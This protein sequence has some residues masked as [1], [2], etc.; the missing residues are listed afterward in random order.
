MHMFQHVLQF[1]SVAVGLFSCG[2]LAQPLSAQDVPQT[3]LIT[4]E[5]FPFTVYHSVG[6]VDRARDMARLC[7]R[8]MEHMDSLLGFRPDVE[9]K[10]LLP[11]DWSAHTDFP[12][13]GMAHYTSQG[14]LV[15]AAVNNAMWDS[16][17]P[18][19]AELPAEVAAEV[20]RV[21]GMADGSISMQPF[22][23]LLV[24]HELGHAYHIQKPAAIPRLW[25]GEQF[26]N[27]LLHTFIAEREPARLD[28]LTLMPQLVVE[29]GSEGF[30]F[31]TL[32]QLED[33]YDLVGQQH[34]RNYGW[35]Q[36]RWH[37]AAAD[38]HDEA[39]DL[40]LRRLWAFLL[41]DP[42]ELDDEELARRLEAEVHPAVARVMTAW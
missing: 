9:L 20:R 30:L 22:F 24:L 37:K 41:S 19:M 8:T 27:I 29:V 14:T 12:V 34:P 23:D 2:P 1:V 11:E 42:G 15:M 38:I 28:A 31:T 7:L 5:G 3:G 4:L 40:A 26:C 13:Y 36:C 6:Q 17:I 18:P 25:M 33:N 39:G 10:V 32:R 35:Y 21:Y 16:F